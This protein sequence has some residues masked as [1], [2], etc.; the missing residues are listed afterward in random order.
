MN[1]IN[2]KIDLSK[3][4]SITQDYKVINC[5]TGILL[6]KKFSYLNPDNYKKILLL[7]TTDPILELVQ[8]KIEIESH[9]S[10]YIKLRFNIPPREGRDFKCP[11]CGKSYLSAPALFNHRKNKHNYIQEGERK[12]RGRPRKDPLVSNTINQS[13]KNM[14]LFLIMI[15]ENLK[16]KIMILI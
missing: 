11:N 12:G 9:S 7:E 6:K 5:N 15:L 8:N 16:V 1:Q 2:T 13:K 3:Y 10:K 4:K 14:K